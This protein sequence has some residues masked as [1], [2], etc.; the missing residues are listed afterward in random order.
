LVALLFPGASRAED[1]NGDQTNLRTKLGIR[2]ALEV[3]FFA[4]RGSAY[5]VEAQSAD[6][7]WRPVFGPV[8]GAGEIVSAIVGGTEGSVAFRLKPQGVI[9]GSGLAPQELEGHSYSLNFGGRVLGLHFATNDGGVASSQ[10][11]LRRGFSF[12]YQTTKLNRAELAIE[13]SDG[14]GEELE[15]NFWRGR[16]G[17][18]Q[19][20]STSASGREH[21]ASGTFRAGADVAPQNAVAPNS[22]E[23][24]RFIFRDRGMVAALTFTTDFSGSLTRAGGV[25]QFISYNYEPS[26]GASASV[27]IVF[28]NSSEVHHYALEFSARN[29]GGFTRRIV[30]GGAVEDTD[31]GKFSG[32]GAEDEDDDGKG[33]GNTETDCIAPDSLQGRTLQANIRGKVV[34]VLLDGA[35]TGSILKRREKGG[36]ALQPFEYTYSKQS[37][38][39]GLLTLTLPSGAGEDEIQIFTL[40]FVDRRRGDCVRK[41]YEDGALDATDSGSFTLS[42]DDGAAGDLYN[43][44]GDDE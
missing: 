36:V 13:F 24:A 2:G 30:R 38:R 34:T 39:E 12:T 5:T 27:E 43:G 42:A 10:D 21:R 28:P 20:V 26:E 1:G 19:G 16:V 25:P 31:R 15:L 29:S 41:R 37:D 40:D 44:G 23:G 7:A 17:V 32:K 4:A 8:F 6:G 11:G 9:S 35:G 18:F 22:L 33:G 14:S 3:E